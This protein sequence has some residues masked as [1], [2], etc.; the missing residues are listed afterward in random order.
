M[1]GWTTGP[2]RPTLRLANLP[3]R[4]VS[5]AAKR[6][7]AVDLI[8]AYIAR[9]SPI[10]RKRLGELRAAIHASAPDAEPA[11]GYGIPAAKWQGRQLV[12]Y[13]AFKEHVSIYPISREF[14][15]AHADALR[16]YY[17]SGRGTLRFPLDA[18]IPRRIV[19]LLVKDRVNDTKA[20]LAAK[21]KRR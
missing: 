11:F 8:R 5:P 1:R 13:A 4:A 9:L 7:D 10:H 16:P 15:K 2:P 17:T 14:E 20:R 12:Y 18:P 21:T 6:T 3:A 19:A